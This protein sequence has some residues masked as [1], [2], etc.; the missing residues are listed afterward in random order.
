MIKKIKIWCLVFGVW[1]LVFGSTLVL[2]QD[3]I[4]I[5]EIV[6]T[7]TKTEKPI[8]S[9]G[10]SVTA[11]TKEQMSK[12][13]KISLLDILRNV[14]GVEIIQQGNFG[15]RSSIYIR[16]TENRHT[17]IL[18]DGIKIKDPTT[19]DSSI[20]LA[21]FTT[22]SIDKIEI[23]RGAQSGIY[24]SDA[25]GGVVNLITKKGE[26]NFKIKVNTEFGTFNTKRYI[27]NLSKGGELSYSLNILNL[28]TD[29]ISKADEILGN[30]E[31]DSYENTSGHLNLEYKATNRIKIGMISNY[32]KADVGL[33]DYNY[34][35]KL[36]YFQ[37]N[38]NYL[39]SP[40]IK[41]N[42]DKKDIKFSY[43][44]F[45]TNRWYEDHGK[46]QDE[47]KGNVKR[48]GLESN[49]RLNEE[50]DILLGVEFEKE[51]VDITDLNKDVNTKSIWLEYLMRYITGEFLQAS[52]RLDK[53]STFGTHQTYKLGIG[54]FYKENTRFFVN[55]SSGFKSP[56]LYQLFAK[57]N[58]DW[59]FLGGNKDLKPEK[60]LGYEI[61]WGRRLKEKGYF[62]IIYFKND[63]DDLIEYYTDPQTWMG[64]YKNIGM[65]NISGFEYL[66]TTNLTKNLP[67]KLTFTYAKAIDKNT[68]EE[69]LYRAK[70]R[71]NLSISYLFSKGFLNFTLNYVG[72]KKD[73]DWANYK[74]VELKSYTKVDLSSKLDIAKGLRLN[75]KIENL[76]D[77]HYQEIFG[78][79]TPGRSFY[80]GLEKEL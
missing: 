13:N 15:G 42:S 56:S 65:V 54:T 6:V 74:E 45:H 58:L 31:K 80:M 18:I 7:A 63:I 41:I 36:N 38:K 23:V 79:G 17:T 61:G 25:V 14:E 62:E 51:K 5:G 20:N 70:R 2:A 67:T 32:V 9:V 3:E 55:L 8:S 66:I 53:H 35:D 48:F 24:G 34:K 19:P 52:T 37:K 77:K 50:N 40:Y 39:V 73:K 44:I 46:K 78:Y 43:S 21:D 64:T 76:T 59:F 22:S 72:K 75:L 27:L 33:D 69:L 49:I 10:N 47:Y 29:G 57:P 30:K 4:D 12:M 26:G 71:A 68:N 16:G 28:K 60:S 11:I 1:Y